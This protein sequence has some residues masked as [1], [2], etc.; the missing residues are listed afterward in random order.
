MQEKNNLQFNHFKLHTQYSICE[1]AIKIEDLKDYCKKN[2]IQT[3]GISD[4]SNLSGA[5]EFSEN[6]AKVGCQPIIGTQIV[7]D[8][9]NNLGLI[10]IIAKN[11]K[12]Y[13]NIIELSSKSYLSNSSLNLPN[14]H[15]DDLL[16]YNENII[17]LS[18]SIS[19]LI[20]KLFDQGKNIEIENIYKKLKDTFKNNFYI[21]IQR[22]GDQNEKSFELFNLTLSKKLMIPIIA[23]NEVYYLDKDMHDAHDALMCIGNK[24][25]LNDPNRNKLSNNHYLK[26][27]DEMKELFKDIPEALENN[28]YLPKRCSYRPKSSHPILPNISSDKGG[29]ADQILRNLSMEGLDKKLIMKYQVIILTKIFLC[30]KID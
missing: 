27:T 1:G 28:Y 23:S 4:T 19:G 11:E 2:K 24:T 12:G 29:D 3:A 26:T 17:V 15:F 6:L 30:T 10:P 9:K 22:H 20:G 8:Y 7:F 5:L 14:C 21:E 16:K 25:Y 18:G 13:Q